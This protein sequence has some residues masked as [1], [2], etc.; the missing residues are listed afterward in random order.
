MVRRA[1]K[2]GVDMQFGFAQLVARGGQTAVNRLSSSSAPGTVANED[3]SLGVIAERRTVKP[4]ATANHPAR[5][6]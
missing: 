5:R 4:C 2:L 6:S 1:G 3:T